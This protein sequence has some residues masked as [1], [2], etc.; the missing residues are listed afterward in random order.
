[1]V[2]NTLDVENVVRNL[3]TYWHNNI[4]WLGIGGGGGGGGVVLLLLLLYAV[5]EALFACLTYFYWL[6][7]LNAPRQPPTVRNLEHLEQRHKLFERMLLRQESLCEALDIPVASYFTQFIRN[8]FFVLPDDDDINDK[9]KSNGDHDDDDD[10]GDNNNNSSSSGSKKKNNSNEEEEDDG[11]VCIKETGLPCKEDLDRLI[12]W[13]YFHAH[14]E[15]MTEDWQQRELA[16]MYEL[17]EKRHHMKPGPK[18]KQKLKAV[19]MTLEPLDIKYRPLIIYILAFL[20]RAFFSA[21]LYWKGFSHHV[22]STGL[23]YWYRPNKKQS[24]ATTAT[25]NPADTEPLPFL[26][27]HGIAPCGPS[28]YVPMIVWGLATNEN[29]EIDRPIFFFENPAVSFSLTDHA[30]TEQE[31]VDGVWEAVDKHCS[32]TTQVSTIGHSF[33][34]CLQTYL[35]HSKQAHRVKQMVLVDPVSIILSDPDVITNFVYGRSHFRNNKLHDSVPN[36]GAAGF[37]MNGAYRCGVVFVVLISMLL[38]LA[39]VF[40]FFF[41]SQTYRIVSSSLQQNCSLN[42]FSVGNLLGTTANSFLKTFQ[43]I[44][45]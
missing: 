16:K 12:S 18:T 24:S 7:K 44:A 42:I 35:I 43:T 21:I 38:F 37:V 3:A 26:V 1:M 15:N 5:A 14:V 23:P 13:G 10:D 20:G 31:T 11:V 39:V 45:S 6:P 41:Y 30:P 29:T 34:T 8:W 33:G 17:I 25:S 32:S 40:F 28:F 4:V 9:N 19:Q 27:F 36:P 22:A 2:W